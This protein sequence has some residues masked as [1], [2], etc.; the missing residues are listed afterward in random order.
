MCSPTAA[1]ATGTA[2][3]SSRSAPFAPWASVAS[4]PVMRRCVPA[5]WVSAVSIWTSGMAPSTDRAA[6][7]DSG[8]MT[9]RRVALR[10]RSARGAKSRASRL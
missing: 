10:S 2:A 6:A 5:N 3:L 9:S 7:S 1:A 4:S 8:S